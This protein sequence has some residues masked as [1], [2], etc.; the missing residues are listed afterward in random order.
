MQGYYAQFHS[1]RALVFG[2]GYREKSHACLRYA[3]E[4]L[5]V[6]TALLSIDVITDFSAAM[7]MRESADYGAVYADDAAYRFIAAAERM[8]ES[9]RQIASR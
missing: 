1:L 2:E 8:L 7:R 5:L 9:A 6:D 3:V 4:A